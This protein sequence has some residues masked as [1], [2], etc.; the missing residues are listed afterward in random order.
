[1]AV[2]LSNKEQRVRDILVRV[3]EGR[4]RTHRVGFI[5]I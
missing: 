4:V 1:M 5:S 3:A 2:N